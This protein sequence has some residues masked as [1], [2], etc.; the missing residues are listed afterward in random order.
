M[1]SCVNANYDAIIGNIFV[2]LMASTYN[3]EVEFQ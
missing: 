3:Y 2:T 1:I